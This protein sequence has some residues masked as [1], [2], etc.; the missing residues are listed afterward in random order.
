MSN[1]ARCPCFLFSHQVFLEG[2]GS[3]KEGPENRVD[4]L[5]YQR[6][7]APQGT[8]GSY[9]GLSLNPIGCSQGHRVSTT[10]KRAGENEAKTRPSPGSPRLLTHRALELHPPPW[11]LPCRRTGS[12]HISYL[13]KVIPKPRIAPVR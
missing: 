5:G 12:K 11:A 7:P 4:S 13:G 9:S 6:P 2:T 10:K 3:Y 1:L 8:L